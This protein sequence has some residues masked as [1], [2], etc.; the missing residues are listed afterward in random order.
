MLTP[1]LSSCHTQAHHGGGP[2]LL[3]QYFAGMSVRVGG[4]RRYQFASLFLGLV[5]ASAPELTRAQEG[6]QISA[7]QRVAALRSAVIT[8]PD[9]KTPI[10]DLFERYKTA[11]GPAR[12]PIALALF[13]R[14]NEVIPLLQDRLERGSWGDRFNALLFLQKVGTWKE[15]SKAVLALLNNPTADS[16]LRLRAVAT[17]SVLGLIEATGA[18]S[19]LLLESDQEGMRTVCAQALGALGGAGAIDALMR[20]LSD[21][22]PR[23]KIAAA[24]ALGKLG[25]DAGLE[26]LL[27]QSRSEDWALRIRAAE[28]LSFVASPKASVRLRE[29]ESDSVPDV[30][31]AARVG[32]LRIEA[33]RLGH[34]ARVEFLTRLVS[35]A[36]RDV[37]RWAIGE[38]GK[39]YGSAAIPKLASA[40]DTTSPFVRAEVEYQLLQLTEESD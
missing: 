8:G 39:R 25:S 16:E 30:R 17:A 10:A 40:L 33:A 26:A 34:D 38:L 37:A 12:R 5:I 9:A 13:L 6:Q 2:R 11:S 24:G 19:D 32:G 14:K 18:I 7:A 36:S 22:L 20:A 1:M 3:L 31:C 28:A 35:D 27:Q 4:T 29:L 21:P 23:V 15:T